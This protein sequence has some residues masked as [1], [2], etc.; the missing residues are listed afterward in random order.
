[1][2]RNIEQDDN[3]I[4]KSSAIVSVCFFMSDV[5]YDVPE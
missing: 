3:A 2:C 5:L 4:V 1:M